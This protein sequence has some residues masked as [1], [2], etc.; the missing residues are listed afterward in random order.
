MI[1]LMAFLCISTVACNVDQLC[2]TLMLGLDPF[3]LHLDPK[4][5]PPKKHP[6]KHETS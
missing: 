6:T 2:R 5:K 3:N 4:K 1:I